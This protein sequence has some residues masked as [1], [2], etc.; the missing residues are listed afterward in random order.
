MI[1]NPTGRNAIVDKNGVQT[2][3]HLQWELS[4]KNS[5]MQNVAPSSVSSP[6]TFGQ[7]ATDGAFLYVCIAP[8]S[9]KRTAL[10]AW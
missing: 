2:R 7:L 10:T 5:Q 3:D 9:W 8:N 6:G 4:V 1:G